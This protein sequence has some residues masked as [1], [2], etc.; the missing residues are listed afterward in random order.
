MALRF[1]TSATPAPLIGAVQELWLLED[2]GELHAGL[3][4]PYV[5][6][7]VSLSGV[8]Y[9]RAGPEEPDHRFS[10]AWLTPLQ[11]GPRYAWSEGPRR[12]IGA[13]LEPWAAHA[14]FGLLPRGDGPPPPVLHSL[15]GDEA[16]RL[17]AS[18][19]SAGDD[20]TRF[21]RFAGWLSDRPA[22]R[23]AR[24]APTPAYDRTASLAKALGVSARS[25]RRRFGA[26]FGMAPKR[27]LRLKRLDCVLRELG[28]GDGDASLAD[29]AQAHG[30]A[31]QAHLT[32]E[33][34]DLTGAT[35]TVLKRRAA[36]TPPHLLTTRGRI[37]QDR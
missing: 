14:I 33:L 15:I 12:L 23:R 31:D 9:W 3:P 28:S 35:P 21:S 27:W 30:F 22:M 8:H 7:V 11:E 10:S 1:I 32:R 13:R 17:R 6:L 25:L 37:L 29:V 24:P 19:M 18:L 26:E 16:D 2:D 36:G 34:A 5:E 20:E 4:K